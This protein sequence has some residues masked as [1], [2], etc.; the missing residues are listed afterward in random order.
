VLMGNYWDTYVFTALQGDSAMVPVPFEDS[1]TRTP[2][3][4]ESV[5]R[6]SLVIVA[7][8]RSAPGAPVSPPQ[9][10]QQYGRTFTLVDPRWHETTAYA[11]AQYV[12]QRR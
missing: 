9:T 7:C 8:P 11:F 2:W 10:L 1:V 3:T 6:A 5:R 4:I 12:L